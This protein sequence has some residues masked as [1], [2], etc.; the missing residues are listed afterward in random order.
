MKKSLIALAALAVVTAAS[1]QSTV[2]LSGSVSMGIQQT[3]ASVAAQTTQIAG[4]DAISSNSFNFTATEDLG[5]GMTATAYINN[6]LSALNGDLGSGDLY[7][8]L[9][10]GFGQLRAGKFTFNSNSGF[11]TFASRAVTTLAGAGQALGANNNVMYTTP[12]FNGLT[13]SIA[14]QPN[15]YATGTAGSGVKVNYAAGPMALQISSTTAPQGE[16][17]ANEARVDSL[18]ASYDLGVAKI[19]FNYYDQRGG[20]TNA[21]STSTA[22]AAGAGNTI[23]L[24]SDTG[25][26]LSVSI[27]MGAATL[28]AGIIDRTAATTATGVDRSAVGVDYALSKRTML[29]AEFATDKHPTTG[30]SKRTNYFVGASHSF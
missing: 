20:E 12:G 5:G 22:W 29:T 7:V 2:T 4:V 8:N 26:S 18:A 23:D 15:Q 21:N 19:F 16:V 25:T 9:S 17:A 1:A 27:P 30:A 14:Y 11:N 10:G 3:G 13:A 24:I 28:R 6:R